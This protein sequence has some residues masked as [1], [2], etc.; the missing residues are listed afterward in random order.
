[1]AKQEI[2]ADTLKKLVME[3]LF[4]AVQVEMAQNKED[5]LVFIRELKKRVDDLEKHKHEHPLEKHHVTG[6]SY[7]D[8]SKEKK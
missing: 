6:I 8:L 4:P 5:L 7:Q 1:M 2:T 3:Y